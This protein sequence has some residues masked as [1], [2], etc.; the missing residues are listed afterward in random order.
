MPWC[1]SGSASLRGRHGTRSTAF[2]GRRG[3]MSSAKGLT[4]GLASL[5][6]RVFCV[7]GMGL[8][9]AKGSDVRP[10]VPR[11]PRFLHGTCREI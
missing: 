5:G 1:P 6:I 4:Y 11:A 8:C 7:I 3:L 9:T 10:G 2:R